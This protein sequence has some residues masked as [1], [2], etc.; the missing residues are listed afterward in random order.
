MDA[1][2]GKAGREK[3]MKINR[4]MSAVMT[5]KQLLRT[6]NRLSTSM[7]RLSSGLK[8]NHAA[9]NP[10]GIAISN[11]MKAQIDA[12]DQAESNA[13]DG[14]SVIQ[15]ADGALGEVSS[16]LQ[17]IRELSVQAANG[18]NALSDRESIQKEIDSLK[19]EVDRISSN[20]E[21]NTKSL[22]DGS[23]DIR[24]YAENATRID[25]SDT[26]NPDIYT[27]SVTE[28]AHQANVEISYV[29]NMPKGDITINGVVM[30]VS[31]GMSEEEFFEGLRNAAEEAGCY[32]ERNL[33][34]GTIELYTSRYG[35]KAEINLSV[36]EKLGSHLGIDALGAEYNEETN[37]YEM[38]T[39]G[40]DA[41]VFIPEALED[42]GFS[43]TATVTTDGNRVRVSDLNG[44]YIDFLLD[45]DYQAAGSADEILE[46]GNFE[47]E[48]TDIGAMTLQIGANQYQ[49][50]DVRIPEVSIES[51]YLDTVDVRPK[52]GA[53]YAMRTLDDAIAK[54]SEI[55]SRIGAFQNRIQIEAFDGNLRLRIP[56]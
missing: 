45:E 55:R 34:N 23:S 51:L 15:I 10:A 9:D 35:S 39:A 16:V 28:A 27:L 5:N 30:E 17:R 18:T 29:N 46:N 56:T 6:E 12:L 52:G 48:V 43:T 13:S 3:L 53:D 26:V 8:I 1:K 22:L 32:V 50:M 4:N 44:F 33:A 11:K 37:S 38:V 42:S 24:V 31:Q 20:T 21:F 2:T 47:I 36:S 14:V 25:I 49:T 41:K 54:L 7:E 40:E 19:K